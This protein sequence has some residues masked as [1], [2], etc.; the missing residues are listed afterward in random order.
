MY[1]H[2]Y[3]FS[4]SLGAIATVFLTQVRMFHLWFCLP[5]VRL[6]F[7]RVLLFL[8]FSPSSP[9]LTHHHCHLKENGTGRRS[10]GSENARV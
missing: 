8:S 4:L 3:Y 10:K 9:P 1:R 6:S 5:S 7:G 2:N